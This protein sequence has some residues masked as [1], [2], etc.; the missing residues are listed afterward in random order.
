MG[1]EK[2]LTRSGVV[3]TDE[4][5]AGHSLRPATIKTRAM[6]LAEV[7]NLKRGDYACPA[8]A[9][10]RFKPGDRVHTVNINP[11]T[12]TRL[13]RYARDKTGT[14]E[15]IRGCHVY[16][17]SAALG[18]GDNPQWLYTIVFTAS[19]LWGDAAEPALTVS[20]EAFEPYLAPA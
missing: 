4:I 9:A 6:P 7:P 16:P 8:P 10:A 19:E 18:A 17:D 2:S 20:I 13:P 3:G 14:V 11:T 5:A 12:H 1:L 15:A